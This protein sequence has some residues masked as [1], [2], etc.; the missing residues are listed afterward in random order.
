MRQMKKGEQAIVV[1]VLM[2]ESCFILSGG[3]KSMGLSWIQIRV[4]VRQGYQGRAMSA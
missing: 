4:L 2:I 3:R 1:S